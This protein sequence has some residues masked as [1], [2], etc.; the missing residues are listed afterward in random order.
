MNHAR[1]RYVAT[2]PGHGVQLASGRLLVCCDHATSADPKSRHIPGA[3][4]AIRS[5]AMLS[6]DF[7]SSWTVSNSLANG[8]ECSIAPLA[9]GSLLMVKARFCALGLHG[10]RQR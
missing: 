5:H 8:D 9:N 4:T 10:K 6:D 3:S 7:G 2:G 1:D